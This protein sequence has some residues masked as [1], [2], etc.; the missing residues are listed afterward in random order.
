MKKAVGSRPYAVGSLV[1]LLVL[2]CA[3]GVAVAQ[4]QGPRRT[5]AQEGFVPVDTL[6]SAQEQLPAA[7]LVMAAYA[8]AWVAV[9]GYLISI[10]TRLGKVEREIQTVSRRVDAGGRR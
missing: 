9:F 4:Q 3:G 7:P 5:P 6:P 10:W 2:V 1:L 8:V